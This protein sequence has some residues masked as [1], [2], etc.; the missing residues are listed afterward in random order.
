MSI[1]E[2]VATAVG[3]ALAPLRFRGKARVAQ[4]AARVV[5]LVSP[6]AHCSPSP[7]T[8]LDVLLRDRI[9]A[10]MWARAYQMETMHLLRALLAPG[11]TFLDV[12]AHIGYFSVLAAG[13]VGAHGRVDAFEPDPGCFEALARNAERLPQ[14]RAWNAAVADAEEKQTLY[15]SP[16]GDEWGWSTLVAPPDESREQVVVE[17]I[18]LDGWARGPGALEQLDAVKVNA[19]GSE[20]RILDGARDI[21]ASFAPVLLVGADPTCLARAG[22]DAESVAERLADLHYS[23]WRIE[24]RRGQ[25]T[26]V[27]LG[28][29]RSERVES[30]RAAGASVRLVRLA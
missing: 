8:T 4:S 18:T 1:G 20:P 2:T 16:R 9:Q 5:S 6:R 11:D 26:G 24:S 21:I 30:E 27:L 12:G 14:L 3:R 23:V 19:Q 13:R 29:P 17:T 22:F 7:G 15:R 28:A 25:N 10:H